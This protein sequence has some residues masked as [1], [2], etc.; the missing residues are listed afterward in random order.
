MLIKPL[1][2]PFMQMTQTLVEVAFAHLDYIGIRYLIVLW[3]GKFG[4]FLKNSS[5]KRT[6]AT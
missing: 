1:D 5:G 2:G 3:L 4:N 6:L